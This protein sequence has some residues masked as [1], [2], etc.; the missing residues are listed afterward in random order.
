[1]RSISQ[2][3]ERKQIRS[4]CY[5]QYTAIDGCVRHRVLRAYRTTTEKPRSGS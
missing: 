3:Y 1:M 2:R 5:H 4:K